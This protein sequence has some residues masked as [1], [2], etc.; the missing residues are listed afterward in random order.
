MK[1]RLFVMIGLAGLAGVLAA[2]AMPGCSSSDAGVTDADG[3]V[4]APTDTKRTPM[5]AAPEEP[6]ETGPAVCPGDTPITAADLTKWEPP[7]PIQNVCTQENLDALKAAFKASTTGSVKFT[8]IKTALGAACTAC[9]FSP[10][11][12]DGGATPNWQVFVE[13]GTGAIDNRTASCFAR[14]KDETC[15][16]TRSQFEL[17]LRTACKMPDCATDADVTACKKKVQSGAC[18]AIT[19]S[20][21]AACPNEQE[22]LDAC[23]IYSSITL[24][25]SGGADGGVDAAPPP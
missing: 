12:T 4:D 11:Q 18:K 1:M 15:G 5:E 20:Y 22:L 2:A 16:R 19:D 13:T 14:L 9:V 17:C 8:E 21:V 23:T 25:C 7:L 6:A 3:G 10:L 24:S